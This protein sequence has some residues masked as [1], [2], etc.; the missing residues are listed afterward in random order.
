MIFYFA[1]VQDTE[2]NW[3]LK[4]GKTK[5]LSKRFSDKRLYKDWEYIKTMQFASEDVI[6]SI[7]RQFKDL[8]IGKHHKEYNIPPHFMGKTEI[9]KP[10][11]SREEVIE[12][13]NLISIPTIT[14]LEDFEG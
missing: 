9:I 3:W 14:T 8:Q 12:R 1:N 6:K 11:I 7:E 5:D 10:E 4:T 13:M 2:G